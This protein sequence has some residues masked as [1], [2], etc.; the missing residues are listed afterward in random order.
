[1]NILAFYARADAKER[2]KLPNQ[3]KL[4][5]SEPVSSFSIGYALRKGLDPKFKNI[6]NMAILRATAGGIENPSASS[7]YL[8]RMLE[9]KEGF[10]YDKQTPSCPRTS[11]INR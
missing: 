1:M 3:N 9:E 4:F 5:Y 10:F 8:G 11:H 2:C 6:I 7:L